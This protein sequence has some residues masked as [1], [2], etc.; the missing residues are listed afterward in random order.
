QRDLFF[1]LTIIC[2]RQDINRDWLYQRCRE[3][4]LEP[5]GYLDLWA[6]EHYKDLASD[7]L[8]LTPRGWV[9]HGDLR[10]GDKVHSA[11]GTWTE[12]VATKHFTD[13]AC[14]KLTFRG[15]A[16]IVAGAGHL[17]AVQQKNRSRVEGGKRVGWEDRVVET[18]RLL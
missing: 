4:E 2:K 18:S 17:W 8:I 1:L 10:V 5:D 13:S 12:V 16:E 9:N 11:D 7:T 15:G 14:R 6:R 3:V